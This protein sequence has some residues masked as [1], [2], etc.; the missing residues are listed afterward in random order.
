MKR[1]GTKKKRHW[2]EFE[3]HRKQQ[4]RIGLTIENK[5]PATKPGFNVAKHMNQQKKQWLY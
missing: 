5:E 3:K 2:L 1:I 4:K